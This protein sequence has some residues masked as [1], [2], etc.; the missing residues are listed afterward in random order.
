MHFILRPISWH[1]QNLAAK[2]YFKIL[3]KNVL[4]CTLKVY[5]CYKI[6]SQTSKLG[7]IIKTSAGSDLWRGSI[8]PPL[9]EMMWMAS[10]CVLCV[11]VKILSVWSVNTDTKPLGR[12]G[13]GNMSH[14]RMGLGSLLPL[15]WPLTAAG[16]QGCR[17]SWTFGAVSAFIISQRTGAGLLQS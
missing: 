16:F 4:I 14:N 11:F 6:K 5:L 10:S 8:S 15:L 3:K 2:V 12:A 7:V 1:I 13:E 17:C 9:E